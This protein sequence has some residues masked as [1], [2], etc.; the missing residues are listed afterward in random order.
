VRSW[1]RDDAGRL[2]GLASGAA[3]LL[4]QVVTTATFTFYFTADAPRIR[5]GLLTRLPPARQQRLGWALD[6]AIEQ[7]GGYFYSRLIL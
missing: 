7:T 6:T 3:G 5:R 1:L 4:F 2:V